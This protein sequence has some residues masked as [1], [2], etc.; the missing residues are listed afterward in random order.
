MKPPIVTDEK[1]LL[2][3]L[4]SGDHVAFEKIYHLY[5]R[6]MIVAALR[7]LKSPELAE[8]LVQ[9]LFLKI[10]EQRLRIDVNQSL[11]AYLYK[12]AKNMAYDT[13]R[14][15]SRDRQ[16]QEHLIKATAIVYD[17]VDDYIY[18]KENKRQLSDAISLLPPQQ[19]KVFTLCKLEEKSYEEVGQLLNITTGTVNNHLT[20]ANQSIREYFLN[21]S[22]EGVAISLI[23]A[24]ILQGSN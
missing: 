9:N 21:R 23:M 2:R 11:N 7:L 18:N 20:R 12:V 5:K 15:I 22:R 24:A 4:Q 6:K 19:Q 17:H 3:S 16:L 10:W 8:E 13:F 1:E 14:K